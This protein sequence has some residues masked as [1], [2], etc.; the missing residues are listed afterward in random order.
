MTG[1][2]HGAWWIAL[3][4]AAAGYV[5]AL[6]QGSLSADSAPWFA[7]LLAAGC[8]ARWP[9]QRAV[10]LA[11]HGLFI[12]VGAALALHLLPGFGNALIVER[13]II[14][15]G[16]APFS[17][18]LNLDKPLVGLWLLLACPWIAPAVS[19]PATA[20]AAVSAAAGAIVLCLGMATMLDGL[21]W[22]PKWPAFGGLWAANNLLLVCMAEEALFRGYVQGGLARHGGWLAAAALP[23][24]ALLFGLAHFAGGWQW[25]ALAALAGLAYG[26]AYRHGGLLAAVAAH[27]L[28]NLAHFGLFSYPMLADR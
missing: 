5:L 1:T 22:D 21:A 4:L 20:K 25:M 15:E 18:H 12:V 2:W 24:S 8:A 6:S 19:L 9:R 28:L 26:W 27:F 11:G 7:L 13:A 17:L 10:R 16:A 3:I 14:S 23:L